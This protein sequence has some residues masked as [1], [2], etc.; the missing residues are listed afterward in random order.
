MLLKAF[1]KVEE[2]QKDH[3][4]QIADYKLMT[5]DAHHIPFK[6][7]FFDTV[8]TTFTLES[9]YDLE[10]V[11]KEMKRVCK[12]NGKILILSRGQSYISLYNEWLK[13]KAARDLTHYGLVEHLNLEKIIENPEKHP[14]LKV[15]HKERKNMGMT[16]IYILEVDKESKNEE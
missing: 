7:N 5:A 8:V 2:L 3:K 6:D 1:E 13:F 12:H 4:I 16:Y 11:L 14:E 10:A 9:T 15:F